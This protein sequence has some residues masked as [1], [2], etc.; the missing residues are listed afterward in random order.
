MQ[1]LILVETEL[2]LGACWIANFNEEEAKDLAATGF[3]YFTTM[4]GIQIFRKPKMFQKY[5]Y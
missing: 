3:D 4:N 2:G 5:R 1:S